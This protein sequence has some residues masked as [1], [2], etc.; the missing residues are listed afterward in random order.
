LGTTLLYS[1]T[2]FPGQAGNQF[3]PY[4]E[5]IA[6]GSPLVKPLHS[7]DSKELCSN[8]M[9]TYNKLPDRVDFVRDIS[10]E[11]IFDTRYR[12]G[13]DPNDNQYYL[14]LGVVY[15]GNEINYYGIG[16]YEARLGDTLWTANRITELWKLQYFELPSSGTYYWLAKGFNDYRNVIQ[17]VRR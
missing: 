6:D 7:L 16:M 1:A 8:E 2:P 10:D 3:G 12:T 5:N 15:S 14:Y 11:A 4:I 13:D 17:S 9:A